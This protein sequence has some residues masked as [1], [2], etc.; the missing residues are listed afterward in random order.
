[1][2]YR[3]NLSSVELCKVSI[4]YFTVWELIYEEKHPAVGYTATNSRNKQ[5]L[6]SDLP[7]STHTFISAVSSCLFL[8]PV[9]CQTLEVCILPIKIILAISAGCKTLIPILELLIIIVQCWYVGLNS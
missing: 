2:N 1:M 4:L 7:L 8:L 9:S 3:P 6:N 5:L